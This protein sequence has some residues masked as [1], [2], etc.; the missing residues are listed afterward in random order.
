[1]S[2]LDNSAINRVN[3]HS[4][5]QALAIGVGGVFVLAWLIRAGVPTPLTL[6]VFAFMTLG[7]FVLRPLVFPIER[8]I[9]LRGTLILGTVLEAAIFPLLPLVHGP[10]PMLLAVIVASAAGSVVYWTTYHAM[11]AAQGDDAARGSQIGA[12]EFAIGLINIAAPAIGGWAMVTGGPRAI[13]WLA[14]GLQLL[15]AAPLIGG[16]ETPIPPDAPG[17]RP[18]LIAGAA[19]MAVDGWISAGVYSVWQVA[20]FIA[21]GEHFGAYGGAMALAGLLGAVASLVVG[22]MID[23]GRG[24]VSV[25]LAYGAMAAATLFKAFSLSSPVLAVLANAVGAFAATLLVP[26]F[27]SRVYTLAKASPCPL[28][29]HAAGEAGWDIGCGSACLLAAGLSAAG[30][31]LAWSVGLAIPGLGLG[32]ALLLRAWDPARPEGRLL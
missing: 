24:R 32:A 20:L 15:A 11:F 7:R 27:M 12:R 18:F 21:V 6:L 26:V 25:G 31:P 23:L 1:M 8:R 16:P 14:A 2:F 10:G 28:R 5:L 29:F 9:G 22:R 3:L 4:T 19:L 13:F 30:L 17:G